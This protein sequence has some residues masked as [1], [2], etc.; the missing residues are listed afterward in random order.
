MIIHS[1]EK[2]LWSGFL[3]FAMATLFVVILGACSDESPLEVVED[4]IVDATDGARLLYYEDDDEST[5]PVRCVVGEYYDYECCTLYG[6]TC[7]Y[8][9]SASSMS[10]SDKCYYGTST[11]S[12]SWC[13]TNYGYRCNYVSSSS[14]KYSSSSSYRY[15]SSSARNSSS[16]VKSSSSIK[17][18]VVEA[19]TLKSKTLKFTLKYYKQRTSC[20]DDALCL[21]ATYSD[22]DPTISFKI[23]FIASGG[24]KTTKTTTNL[25]SLQDQG[26]WSGTVTTTVDVPIGTQDIYVC[27][28]VI[29]KDV[30][31]NDDKSSGYCYGTT[32]IGYLDD[33]E[34]MEQSDSK[35]AIY[36]LKWEW[37]LY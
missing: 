25:I 26:T 30:L 15:S 37:F 28:S 35:T 3:L 5:I 22:G 20:W 36:T 24:Q 18:E 8:P 21:S 17:V 4:D 6:Y 7:Y 33:Y 2:N 31:S 1:D 12:D 34:V 13:C 10:E 32:N 14:R 19:H 16:S 9:L 27:P 23:E 11:Y 29:D